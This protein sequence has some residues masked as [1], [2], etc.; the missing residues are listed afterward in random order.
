M[1]QI[2]TFVALLAILGVLTISV[3]VAFRLAPETW[4]M[5][6]G[7]IFGV[8]AALPMCAIVVLLLRQ[9]PAPPP[10]QQP[11]PPQ[12]QIILLHPGMPAGMTYPAQAAPQQM[13]PPGPPVYG[14]PPART[15]ARPAPQPAEWTVGE[16]VEDGEAEAWYPA[17]PRRAAAP[18]AY[19]ILGDY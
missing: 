15:Q 4:A 11:A 12:P 3:I 5:V 9:R 7:V 2:K 10:V 18:P 14:W 8:V 19:R 6:A 1:K 16:L 13:L 17:A